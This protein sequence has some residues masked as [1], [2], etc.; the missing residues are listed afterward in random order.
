MKNFI[1]VLFVLFFTGCASQ[2][3]T[4]QETTTEPSAIATAIAEL[5]QPLNEEDVLAQTKKIIADTP[6]M[7]SFKQC[8]QIIIRPQGKDSIKTSIAISTEDGTVTNFNIYL[9]LNLEKKSW[10]QRHA[11]YV[12][13][14]SEFLHLKYP[15]LRE[16]LF[17]YRVS[18][19]I[20]WR[21]LETP[22][23]SETF[24]TETAKATIMV[25]LMAK[26]ESRFDEV[27]EMFQGCD[28]S[29][30][31]IV[32]NALSQISEK[33]NDELFKALFDKNVDIRVVANL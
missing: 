24:V 9:S 33:D 30:Y 17:F 25:A 14:V 15:E 10:Q 5:P 13:K 18:S 21:L 19:H 28:Y 27:F 16:D 20:D 3:P 7:P 1:T 4:K 26:L 8:P 32:Y 23:T 31:D 22:I 2:E 11:E 6:A 29:Y 12:D